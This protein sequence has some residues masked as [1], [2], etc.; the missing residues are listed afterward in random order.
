MYVLEV[1]QSSQKKLSLTFV[2]YNDASKVESLIDFEGMD[3]WT[4]IVDL[5]N[6]DDVNNL[7]KDSLA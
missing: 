7:I 3:V 2:D 4:Q 5:F 1:W 6:K